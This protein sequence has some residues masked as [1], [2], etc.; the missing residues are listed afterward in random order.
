M[1]AYRD[2]FA[3]ATA[4]LRLLINYI[5]LQGKWKQLILPKDKIKK[6][7]EQIKDIKS[8]NPDKF[9]DDIDI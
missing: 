8:I 2:F 4:K 3:L 1:A 7:D 5:R 6:I 9:I